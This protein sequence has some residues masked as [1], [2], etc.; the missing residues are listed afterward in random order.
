MNMK[1]RAITPPEWIG[2]V[3]TCTR[4]IVAGDEIISVGKGL[5]TYAVVLAGIGCRSVLAKDGQRAIV[6]FVLPGD[7]AL[8]FLIEPPIP[9]DVG[10]AALTP[11]QIAEVSCIELQRQAKFDS[12]LSRTWLRRLQEMR[13]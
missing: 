11:C 3:P 13:A 10:V 6:G 1:S 8:P 2:L 9:A 4:K 7:F 12:G 5:E